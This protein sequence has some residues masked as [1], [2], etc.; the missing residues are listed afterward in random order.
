MLRVYQL[1][2]LCV[3]ISVCMCILICKPVSTSITWLSEPENSMRWYLARIHSLRKTLGNQ[4]KLIMPDL[5]NVIWNFYKFY[6]K[7]DMSLIIL[8]KLIELCLLHRTTSHTHT[9]SLTIPQLNCGWGRSVVDRSTS[10]THAQSLT[11]P[12]SLNCPWGRSVVDRS[13]SH[14]HTLYLLLS[15]TH[16]TVPEVG[17]W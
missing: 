6:F 1:L 10:H 5:I 8:K 2:L 3:C 11:I 4:D 13:T 16:S 7:Y 9:L 15:P 17:L 12:N 14:T